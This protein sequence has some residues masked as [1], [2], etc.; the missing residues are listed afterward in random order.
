M[1][2]VENGAAVALT[3]FKWLEFLEYR[4]AGD[5]TS[6]LNYGHTVGEVIGDVTRIG[7]VWDVLQAD[8][9]RAPD[10]PIIVTQNGRAVELTPDQWLA[11][12]DASLAG[13]TESLADYGS[14]LGTVAQVHEMLIGVS[15][16]IMAAGIRSALEA[17]G[18][19][20]PSPFDQTQL[21]KAV[22]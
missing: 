15:A 10:D 7:E 20:A 6:V 19:L 22:A 3:E 14:D 2:V 17:R 16:G 8:V 5:A 9:D 1:I 12:L 18:E 4:A 13:D 21:I 11:Y